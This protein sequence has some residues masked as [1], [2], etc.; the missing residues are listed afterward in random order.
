MKRR[1]LTSTKKRVN[2]S[3]ITKSEIFIGDTV[4][5]P[6]SGHSFTPSLIWIKVAG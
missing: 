4:T 3:R 5:A 2:E 1:N 6:S